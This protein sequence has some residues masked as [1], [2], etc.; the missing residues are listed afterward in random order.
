MRSVGEREFAW[1]KEFANLRHPREPLYKAFYDN[2]KVSPDVQMKILRDYLNLVPLLVPEQARLS[3]PTI[4]HP[5]LSPSN[6]LVSDTGEITGL[7]DWQHTSVLPLFLQAKIPKHFQN[8]GDEDS[9]NFRAPRLPENFDDLEESEQASA[10]ET[11]RKRQMHYFYV[12]FTERHN[13]LH[14]EAIAEPHLVTVNK[15]YDTA[16]RPWEGDN[17]SLKA[18]IIKLSRRWHDVTPSPRENSYLSTTLHRISLNVSLLT[19]NS[20]KLMRRCKR[21]AIALPQI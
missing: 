7:I 11:Y 20:K 14:F 18:E 4:R 15:L 13:K 10:L 12:G 3:R 16:A 19:R 5:D 6:I 8:W 9:E 1:L 17:T 21:C 2:Q